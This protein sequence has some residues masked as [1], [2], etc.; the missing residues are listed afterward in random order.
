MDSNPLFMAAAV[1]LLFPFFL[2]LYSDELGGTVAWFLWGFLPLVLT[3]MSALN[4]FWTL[5]RLTWVVGWGVVMV[6]QYVGLPVG[7]QILI[8][9]AVWYS[10]ASSLS[11]AGFESSL[12]ITSVAAFIISL[13]VLGWT[14]FL[15]YT[16]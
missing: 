11:V 8:G 9:D 1:A 4:H 14:I 15:M 5:F 6:E 10:N 13:C 2:I 3:L 12:A 16:E 7:E